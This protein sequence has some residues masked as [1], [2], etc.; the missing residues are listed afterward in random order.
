MI[1][2]GADILFSLHQDTPSVVNVAEAE[3]VL[4]VN[5]SSD[6]STYGPNS[7]IAA[8]TNDWGDYFVGKVRD[9]MEGNFEGGDFRGGLASGAVKVVG[10]SDKLSDEQMAKIKAKEA[11]FIDGSDH[12]FAGPITDQDGTV[13][14]E[15]GANV[16]DPDIFGMNWLVAGVD[17]SMPN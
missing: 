16:A 11:A 2:Q 3:G 17:G 10:W 8:V 7:A 4:V 6:M 9:H 1:S 12:A 5:T 13:R 14:A 15:A